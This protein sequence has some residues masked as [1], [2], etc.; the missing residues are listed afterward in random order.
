MACAPALTAL[1]AACA[2]FHTPTA[3]DVIP[4]APKL[5]FKNLPSSPVRVLGPPT[6][7]APDG[8][9]AAGPSDFTSSGIVL[10]MSECD[11][12][13]R[14]GAPDNI[15]LTP[16]PTGERAL[17]LTY[18]HGDRPGIYRFVAG[19]LKSIER[20]A[21]PPPP[22]PVAKKTKKKAPPKKSAGAT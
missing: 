12:I 2:S 19:R 14:A 21:E 5:E 20:G 15:D 10:E 7:M 13:Q 6:L 4:L 16:R 11:V 17:V 9:C 8:S 22:E 18:V 1:A 3:D